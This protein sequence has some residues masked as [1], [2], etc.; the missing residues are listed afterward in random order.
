MSP[1]QGRTRR[2]T[3][4]DAQAHLRRAQSF[5]TT[6]EL[7]SDMGVDQ[8]LE[9][10]G[11]AAAL[12]VLAGIAASDAACCQALGVHPRG[13]DHGQAPA[14]LA[15]VQPDGPTMARDL[16][17]LLDLKN[18]AHYGTISISDSEARRAVQRA[19]R[20][21]ASARALARR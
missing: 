14:L 15:A 21:F 7:V 20:L 3:A 2:C 11:V 4:S 17:R 13:Q 5:L 16:R 19:A 1:Q 8:Q 18:N 6:A 10:P 12:A 9:L